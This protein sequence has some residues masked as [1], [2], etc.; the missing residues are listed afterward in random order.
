MSETRYSENHQRP[1]AEV[2]LRIVDQVQEFVETRVEML[3][4]EM[5]EKAEAIKQSLP[6]AGVAVITLA[7]TYLL[8]ILAL[9]TLVAMAFPASPYRWFFAFVIVGAVWGGIGSLA[10]FLAWR[11]IAEQGDLVPHKTVKVLKEDKD[12]LEKEVRGA[13]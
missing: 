6:L 7:T 11:R 3:R 1:V 13:A 2:V 9:V 8:F 4:A 5:R 10:A 12:W